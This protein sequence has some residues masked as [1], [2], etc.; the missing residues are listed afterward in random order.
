MNLDHGQHL[1]RGPITFAV[2][3]AA[4]MQVLDMTIANVAIPHMQGSFSTDLD[5][6]KWVL[7]SYIVASAVATPLMGWLAERYGRRNVLLV[8]VAGFAFF[9][10][11][12]GASTSLTEV[13]LARIF[14]GILGAAFTPLAQAILL[15]TYPRERH[16]T[17]MA[18]FVMGILVGPVLG[19][20]VGGYITEFYSWRWNFF[21]NVPLGL[22]T[23]LMIWNF[24][25]V[26]PHGKTRNFD[27]LGFIILSLGVGAL[28]FTFDRGS[29][30]NWFSSTEIVFAAA[31]AFVMLWIYPWYASLKK[32][33]F[34]SMRLFRDRNFALG[35][36]MML[37]IG[38]ALL[39]TLS[40]LPPMM[41]ELLNY[42]VF[43]TG[44]ILAPRGIGALLAAVLVG[45]LITRVDP[46]ALIVAGLLINVF[47]LYELSR[48]YLQIDDFFIVWTGFVQ[49][50]GLGLVFVPLTTV[51]FSTLPP[52]LRNEATPI[53]NLIRNIGSSIGISIVFTLLSRNVQENHAAIAESMNPFNSALTE[54]L[55]KVPMPR[56]EALGILNG[57]ITR[58]ATMIAY[59]DDFLLM[60]ALMLLMVPFA[61]AMRYRF[62][63]DSETAGD[64]AAA[65]D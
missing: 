8:S 53:F 48:L 56:L 52:Q 21:I 60:S 9:S 44:L 64:V 47:A 27:M 18:I 30:K 6:I 62:G 28:Q 24:L 42:P 45:R 11:M 34:V 36:L 46:R 25:P 4:L 12:V 58:Q 33:P 22:I 55:H 32:Q 40:L 16:G 13:V 29:A 61:M 59:N 37:A 43:T 41:Q 65:M 39:A 5:S 14:Q 2:M 1:H 49:G 17:A 23:F 38:M 51:A 19:P 54:F 26:R 63:P 15:D 20:T 7:T 50:I 10:F 31:T 35:N 3:L 57:E